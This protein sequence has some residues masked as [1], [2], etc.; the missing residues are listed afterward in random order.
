MSFVLR[1]PFLG[2]TLTLLVCEWANVAGT[3][4]PG[5]SQKFQKFVF[6]AISGQQKFHSP[7]QYRDRRWEQRNV[8]DSVDSCI[9]IN[10]YDYIIHG[11]HLRK[12]AVDDLLFV[13]HRC[14]IPDDRVRF[15]T[16]NNYIEY[17]IGGRKRWTLGTKEYYGEA[18]DAFFVRQGAY[19][20]EKFFDTDFCALV[21][22]VPDRFIKTVLSKYPARRPTEPGKSGQTVEPIMQ[23]SSDESLSAY[24]HS[25][26]SYFRK[27]ISPPRELLT[28]KFEE[29]ILNIVADPR[30]QDVASHFHGIQETGKVPIKAVMETF[31]MNNMSL[32]EYARLCARSLSVFKS[33]FYEIYGTSPGKWLTRKRL[34]YAKFLMETTDEPV[35]EVAFRSGFRNTS[36][37]VRIFKETYGKPPLQYR[38]EELSL[39]GFAEGTRQLAG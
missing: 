11:N 4:L 32:E 29:L 13:E 23:L 9:V 21:I 35:G 39:D 10:F 22:F 7:V 19:V 24:F 18:G 36:H 8:P 28:I 14:V 15:W 33:E 16:H 20:A 12:F 2:D 30:N 38:K 31:F 26:L 1:I 34:E 27:P 25:V 17:I 6:R 3:A 5:F 37:F